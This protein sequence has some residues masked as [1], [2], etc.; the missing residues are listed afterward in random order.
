SATGALGFVPAAT[1]NS[2]PLMLT[3][4]FVVA[5]G[6]AIQQ[7]VANPYVIALGSPETGAHRVSLAG[8]IN[9]FGT[10]IGPLLS[11][12]ALF[13][14]INANSQNVSD[15]NFVKTP[16]TILAFAF[17]AFAL[18][19]G[20]SKLPPV[21]NNEKMEKNFGA[22]K[23]PQLLLGM[24]AIFIYVGVEV[25]TQSN[26]QA[27]IKTSDFLG[28]DT[29][30]SVHFISLYWGCLMIGRWIGALT[31]FNLSKQQKKIATVLVPFIV[32]GIIMGV[33]FI[34]GSPMQDFI[35]FIPFIL[36]LITA[37]FIA[38][39]NPA[40]TMIVF[41]SIAAILMLAGI[42]TNGRLAVYLF[43]SGGLFCSVMWP[44]IFSLSIA[45][46]GKYTNQGSAL[47]IMMIIGGAFIP[48]LQ[49]LLSDAIGIHYSY[50]I[51]VICFLYLA[52]YGFLVNKTLQKQGINYE[53]N[54]T[55]H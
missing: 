42:F 38:G 46:L 16:Y 31:I 21:S 45:G 22:L 47:L 40:R 7:I 27:L 4:L 24:L 15:I 25:S 19:L 23:Y 37:F 5:F 17:I 33:N 14:S 48:P 52:L 34:K 20:F 9:S 12:Y 53:V 35:Y 26:L 29:N 50:I 32:L 54:S 18:F 8:G 49:G 30:K 43:V 36:I 6:F 11:S 2:Y 55:V 3:S 28:L 41:G 1:L 13:G 44:C 39:E 51:P 10:T